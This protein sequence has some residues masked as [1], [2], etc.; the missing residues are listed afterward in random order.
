M[1]QVW[2]AMFCYL[3]LVYIKYQSRYRGTLLELSQVTWET[4]M[5]WICS[6]VSL[7]MP[8]ESTVEPFQ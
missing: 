8:F 1:T 4:L 5:D 2:V 3:M 6:G 7:I